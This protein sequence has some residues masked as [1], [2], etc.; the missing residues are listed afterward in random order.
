MLK[1]LLNDPFDAV[2]EMLDGF[3]TA[4]ADVVRLAAPRVI[5]RREPAHDKVGLVVGG[6]SGHEPAFAGYVGAGLADAAACGN[7]FAAPSPD[8]CLDAIRA[9][10]SGRGVLLCYGNYAGDVL[11]FDLAAELAAG[12]GIATATLRVSDDVASAPPQDRAARRG[13]AGDLFVFKVAGAAAERGD[14]LA[15]VAALA[16]RANDACR[17]LGVALSACEVPGSGRPT[18]EIGPDE[19]EIGMGVHGEPGIRRGTLE[20]ADAVA[21]QMLEAILADWRADGVEGGEA[22]L[23]VNGLGATPYMDLYVLYRAARRGLEAAG[24]TVSRSFV[25]EYVTSLEMAGA[26]FSVL[27]LDDELRVLLDAPARTARLP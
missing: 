4:H 24:W 9:A 20:P 1:K 10:S 7:V 14:D 27:R 8:V 19:L 16:G 17:S 5:G 13:I 23:L 11:N 25:G 18:F 22:A 26:S 3:V 2:D 6:G 12:E 15:G 21:E